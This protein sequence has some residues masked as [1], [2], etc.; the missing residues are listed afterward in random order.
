MMAAQPTIGTGL[1][2]TAR[3]LVTIAVA[4]V[5]DAPSGDTRISW[6]RRNQPNTIRANDFGFSDPRDTPPNAFLSVKIV[7]LP[8]SALGT[9]KLI[10]IGGSVATAV[11]V[12]VN[13]FIDKTALDAG[14]LIFVPRTNVIGIG[15]FNF[16]VKDNGGTALGG[17]DLD[18]TPNTMIIKV[19]ICGFSDDDHD[20][21]G[22]P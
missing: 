11:P 3:T 2:T 9:L 6:N 14:R 22:H 17:V 21:H 1:A 20:R 19:I 13:T 4:S 8:S 18:P 7:S 12:P 10:P 5:N 16:Q 15:T